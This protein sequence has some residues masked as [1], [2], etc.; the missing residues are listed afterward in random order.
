[1]ADFASVEKLMKGAVAENIFPG[2]V[3]LASAGG[4]IVFEQNFGFAQLE[5]EPELASISTIYD[6]AS[7]TKVIA[8]TSATMLLHGGN[9]LGLSDPVGAFLSDYSY[10]DKAE[11]SIRH[12]L[13]H[14]SGYPAWIGLYQRLLDEQRQSGRRVIGEKSARRRMLEML[15]SEPLLFPPGEQS[16][17]SD[18]DFMLLGEIIELVSG[19]RLDRFCARHIFEPLGM[20]N[21]FFVDLHNRTAANRLLA[22]HHFAATEKSSWRGTMIKGE[23]HDDNAFAMGGIAGH[24]GLFST[25][26]DLHLLAIALV[27]SFKGLDGIFPTDSTRQFF[28]RQSADISNTWA[29]G[30]DTPTPGKSASGQHFSAQTVGHLGFTGTSIWIDLERFFIVLLLTNRVHPDRGNDG[31]RKFRPLLHD[32]LMKCLLS[33]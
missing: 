10:G 19:Q 12:L 31:I 1:V 7:L 8:T 24:A 9:R 16:L 33:L 27:E 3:L 32:E 23:V 4:E 15:H 18:L 13:G 14:T 11:M 28:Q 29:L 5:P 25:A 21:T 22:T 30:W 20:I 6:L 2:G 26:S 17:Y